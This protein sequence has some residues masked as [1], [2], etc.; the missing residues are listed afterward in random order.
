MKAYVVTKRNSFEHLKII[1]E[2]GAISA[3]TCRRNGYNKYMC[4][5][6]IC[7]FCYTEDNFLTNDR[8][9]KV[10]NFRYRELW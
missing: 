10:Q 7:A 4:F 6:C 8:N 9:G 3:E 5:Y 2:D 1:L